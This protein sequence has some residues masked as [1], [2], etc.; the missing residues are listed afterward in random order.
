MKTIYKLATV[1]IILISYQVEAQGDALK[2]LP[3]GNVGIG[4]EPQNDKLIVGGNVHVDVPASDKPIDATTIDVASFTTTDNA[5]NSTYFRV[6]D[7]ANNTLPFSIRGDGKVGIGKVSQ[8]D[9]LL[10]EGNI[11]TEVP[12]S[13]S[14][15]HAMTV[16]VVTFGTSENAANSTYFR[17]RD[18]GAGIQNQAFTVRGNGNVGIGVSSPKIALDVKLGGVIGSSEQPYGQHDNASEGIKV[19]FGHQGADFIG[20]RTL[21]APGTNGCGKS[22]DIRF[23]T[24]ECNTGGSKEVMRISG[25]GNV[26]IGTSDTRKAKLVVAADD[27]SGF[28]EYGRFSKGIAFFAPVVRGDIRCSIY[29]SS[30][31]AATE[32]FAFSDQRI[33][34]II[35]VSNKENDLK[36]L[37]KIEVTDYKMIDT[38]AKGNQM[39][40]KVIAQ[41]VEKV[42][43]AAVNKNLTDVIPNIYQL[44]A[45]NNGWIEVTAKDLIAG[46]KIKLVFSNEQIIVDVLEIDK[47]KIKVDCEKE[48]NV[49]VYGKQVDDFRTVDYEAIAMLN[50]S[51]TQALLKRI[52]VLEA[53]DMASVNTI[54]ELKDSQL[55]LNKR[56]QKIEERLLHDVAQN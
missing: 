19:S 13:S 34:N 17:V 48:G 29:A 18:I 4:K 50:V 46:D 36:I 21:V 26:G 28:A 43:P 56:L 39:Y 7:I 2:I 11:H 49:F 23:D 54:N 38:I 6:R 12:G 22:G 41:Q 37:S 10:V 44:S 40:K 35:G 51:A 3:N 42:Y 8:D 45:I 55:Q 33:K 53:K 24:W 25:R 14:P 32:F 16:D 9:K 31:I 27:Y 5:K 30:N 47:G 52:E 1:L 15:I 20:M